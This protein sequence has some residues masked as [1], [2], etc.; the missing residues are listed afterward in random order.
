MLEDHAKIE[1]LPPESGA[2]ALTRSD[3]K[4]APRG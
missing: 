2:D 3:P 1:R 4:E